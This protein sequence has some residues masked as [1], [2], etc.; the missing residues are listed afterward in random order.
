MNAVLIPLSSCCEQGVQSSFIRA[1][2]RSKRNNSACCCFMV[3]DGFAYASNAFT[4]TDLSSFP[5]A[6]WGRGCVSFLL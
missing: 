1:L 2:S 6:S 3:S 5:L 4:A